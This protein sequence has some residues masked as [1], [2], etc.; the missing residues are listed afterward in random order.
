MVQ[1]ASHINIH[2][3]PLIHIIKLTESCGKN[4]TSREPYN[5]MS[6]M[7]TRAGIRKKIVMRFGRKT[8]RLSI[9]Q[10]RELFVVHEELIC[11]SS[12]FRDLLQPKRKAIVADCSICQEELQPDEEEP[13]YCASS[14]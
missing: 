14:C 5:I 9:G 13:T 10:G 8:V 11:T 6:D 1:L 7:T 12:Y 3:L 4:P 2:Y